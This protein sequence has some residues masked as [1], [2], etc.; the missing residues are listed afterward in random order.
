[1]KAKFNEMSLE[2]RV[3][4]MLA[5]A[6]TEANKAGSAYADGYTRTYFEYRNS[7]TK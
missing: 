7:L 2:K 3:L 4:A 5:I 1:M 6:A